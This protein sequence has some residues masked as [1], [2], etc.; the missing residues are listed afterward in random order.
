MLVGRFAALFISI[1]LSSAISCYL[2]YKFEKS[3]AINAFIMFGVSFLGDLFVLRLL[4]I[5]LL[6]LL[7]L[8]QVKL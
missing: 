4:Y 5:L 6:S 7:R 1:T 2:N 3:L 8:G